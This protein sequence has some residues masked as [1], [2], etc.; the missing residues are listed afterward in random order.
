MHKIIAV[1][2]LTLSTPLRAGSDAPV[3]LDEP[4]VQKPTAPATGTPAP[5]A[6]ATLAPIS[7]TFDPPTLT[8]PDEMIFRFDVKA[9]PQAREPARILTLTPPSGF[10]INPAHFPYEAAN[11]VHGEAIIKRTS[12]SVTGRIVVATIKSTKPSTLQPIHSFF[13]FAY[14]PLVAVR[15]FFLLG[16]L[17]IAFGWGVRV[18]KGLLDSTQPPPHKLALA[19]AKQ[20]VSRAA[21]NVN[22]PPP[23]SAPQRAFWRFWYLADFIVAMTIGIVFLITMMKNGLP[24]AAAG[25]PANTFAIAFGI[26]LLT[27]TELITKVRV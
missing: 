24:P 4:I 27:N 19:K 22:A 15:T 14:V 6:A 5:V 10:A 11:G 12:G 8:G 21:A 18:L 7:G 26:G 2:L 23:P 16:A 13:S 9:V 17:G 1:V 20:A 3:A 25:Y